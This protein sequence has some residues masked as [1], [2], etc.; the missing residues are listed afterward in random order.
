ML[1]DLPDDILLLIFGYLSTFEIFKNVALICKNCYRVSR[2][3]SFIQDLQ[4]LDLSRITANAERY[5]EFLEVLRYQ[6]KN[7]A[8]LTFHGI[9]SN[10]IIQNC[11]NIASNACPKLSY[12][13]LSYSMKYEHLKTTDPQDEDIF[14]MILNFK[15]LEYFYFDYHESISSIGNVIF[16]EDSFAIF[17]SEHKKVLKCLHYPLPSKSLHWLTMTEELED[18]GIEGSS[19][20]HSSAI[21]LTELKKL[22]RLEV[23]NL[24]QRDREMFKIIALGCPQLESLVIRYLEPGQL[25]AIR[26]MYNLRKLHITCRAGFSE[27][28]CEFAL[29]FANKKQLT[30]LKLCC[31]CCR[32]DNDIQCINE[33]CI[34]SIALECSNLESLTLYSRNKHS[35]V[36]VGP[37]GK[38]NHLKNL[39]LDMNIDVMEEEVPFS[40]HNVCLF[41]EKIFNMK[42]LTRLDLTSAQNVTD[43][44]LKTIA[45][46]CPKLTY[47]NLSLK[48]SEYDISNDGINQVITKCTHLDVLKFKNMKSITEDCLHEL[49]Q[50][51]LPKLKLLHLFGC[52]KI[53]TKYLE[54]LAL[55]RK[56]LEILT[57]D[58]Q[59]FNARHIEKL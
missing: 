33:D 51:N 9:A 53:A 8:N 59:E 31:N 43:R 57:P 36:K 48:R 39:E 24:L 12:L 17:L 27:N 52:L 1:Q 55:F 40:F 42:D 3:Y 41:D 5:F 28:N 45:L 30:D 6:S 20:D 22:K 16:N 29:V 32:F 11:L 15:K 54:K 25:M 21:S 13:D 18:L 56:T 44:M 26:E 19:L 37:L 46:K 47:L 2:D 50:G 35:V 23:W 34:R 58:G 4:L 7:L 10:K 38:L 49:N 14:A